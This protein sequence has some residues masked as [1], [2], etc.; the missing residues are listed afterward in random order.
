MA[1]DAGNNQ[2]IVADFDASLDRGQARLLLPDGRTRMSPSTPANYASPAC[3][4]WSS[5]STQQP[6]RDIGVEVF[7]FWCPER[8][9]GGRNL[10]VTV[11]PSIGALRCEPGD[12]RCGSAHVCA[13]CLGG[14]DRGRLPDHQPGMAGSARRIDRVELAFDVDFDHPMESALFGHPESVM[15]FCVKHY[16]ICDDREQLVAEVT[17]NHQGRNTVVFDTPLTTKR[18]SIHLLETHGNAPARCLGCAA[19]HRRD[20]GFHPAGPDCDDASSIDRT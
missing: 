5:A 11:E 12:Q 1:L 7:D 16:R 9:P 20:P 4:R 18:L 15:P 6:D 3:S 14:G 8:R 17:E 2:P 10:A 13:Q 19:T